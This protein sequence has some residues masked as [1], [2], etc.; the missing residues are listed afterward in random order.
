VSER[1][2]VLPDVVQVFPGH[3][4]GSLCGA[5]MS[6]RPESTLGEER[7]T[8]P[9]FGYGEKKF[10]RKILEASPEM[11]AYYPLMKELNSHGAA[12]YESLPEMKALGVEGVANSG[13]TIVDLRKPESFGEAH[14]PGALNLGLAGNL[15]M[16]SGWLLPPETEV[17]FVGETE[18][19]CRGARAALACVGLDR[20]AGYL[21]GGMAAW[22]AACRNVA[23]TKQASPTEV[24]QTSG[25]LILDVRN[26]AERTHGGIVGARGIALGE[27]LAA[28]PTLNRERKIVTVCG[29]GY[30]SSAAASLLQR[31]GFKQVSH[32]AGGM[33]AW[34]SRFQCRS[35]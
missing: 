28:F 32:L 3:G 16:W 13:A 29:T 25:A 7:T 35:H 18:E 12:A 22:V 20:V 23:Q 33:A 27:L 6:D 8:N 24:E 11:P 19:D 1:I 5:G 21:S 34:D 9:Y 26:A 2:A 15:A 17:V 4:A 31:A 30:R 10:V 14:I